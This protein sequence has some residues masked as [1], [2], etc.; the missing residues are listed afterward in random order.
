M[1]MTIREGV[2]QDRSEWVR[3]RDA[4]WPGS[5]WDHDEET[6]K[7]FAH[8]S[9]AMILF[10]AELDGRIVG[11]LD[12]EFRQY[13]PDCRSSPVPFIEGWYV[14][15]AWQRRGIGRARRLFPAIPQRGGITMPPTYGSGKICD[16]VRLKP[17][18]TSAK[19]GGDDYGSAYEKIALPALIDT[20]CLPLTE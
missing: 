17:D 12:L 9:T 6:R 15:P 5:L 10:V 18:A 13:A 3:L 16:G 2:E 14:E 20:Y 7:Y 19:A 11:F 8:R 1:R 4:L